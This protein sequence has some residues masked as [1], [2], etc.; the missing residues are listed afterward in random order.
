MKKTNVA[1]VGMGTVGTGV[2]RLILDHGDRTSRHAGRTIWLKKAVVR[3]LAKPREVDLP[4]GVV[5]DSLGDVIHDPEISVVAQ[6]IGG[7]EPARTIMLQL[8]E[9]GKDI[10]TAN[11]ALL[12]EHGPEL[13]T[14]ARELGRSIAFEA[15]VAG[16]IPIIAN[17]SQCL[18]ANQLQSLEGILNG[19]SNFIVT[20][21]D[22][23]GA[24]YDDV[25]KQAQELGY[26]EAD[27][28]MDVDGTDAAQKLAILAHLAFGATVDW[29]DIPKIGID[30]LDPADLQYAR[31]LGYR[32]KLLAVANLAD[33]GL[34]LS[35]APTLVRIGTPLAE[36]RDAFNAIR[37]VGDAVGPVF[38]HGLG[39]GQMPT[40]S[41]VVADVIDTAVG[42]TKLTFQTL[43]YFNIEQP[44]RVKLLDALT[45]MGRYYFRL[46]VAN[47]PGTLA[48]IAA[49][50]EKHAISIAS[51]IQ[52]EN[53]VGA[54]KADS[55][56]LV[57]MTHEASEGSAQGATVAIEAL[58]AVTG[59]VVRLRVKD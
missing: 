56:P 36:V 41:A 33:D 59:P 37:V 12:A 30:N 43:E 7:L 13:F 52:H 16:G 10:V 46:H 24:S 58:A 51:V 19:T 49:V 39:A 42:R 6:L 15:A 27:P 34:E 31:E 20:Q 17:I 26:A 21:M 50:L 55:V 1:I 3:D 22:E 5:T 29:S 23:R 2:A 32:I 40:A 9:S 57:I 14:R 45:L 11:K 4:D 18:S 47:H 48:A 28:T 54:A 53:T 25:V 38:Y 35:V 44:P 8:M